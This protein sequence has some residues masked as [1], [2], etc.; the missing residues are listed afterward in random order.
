MKAKYCVIESPSVLV[1]FFRGLLEYNFQIS[2]LLGG[3]FCLSIGHLVSGGL[4]IADI[5]Q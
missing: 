2:H 1:Y 5:C 4:R 3:N